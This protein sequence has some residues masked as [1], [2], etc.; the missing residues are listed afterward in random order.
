[1]ESNKQINLSAIRD[2]QWVYTKH[3]LD[4]LELTTLNLIKADMTVCD[5]GTGWGFPLMPLAI[6]YPKTHFIWLDSTAKKLKA[7]NHIT[8]T[9][10]I[11]NVKTIR[12]RAED[13]KQKY[14]IITARAVS[15]IDT[16][17]SWTSHL[18][19]PSGLLVLYK[20]KNADEYHD[21][22]S[23]IPDFWLE[24]IDQHEYTIS[25]DDIQ[26]ILYILKKK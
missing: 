4:S 1:M 7:I 21:L 17:L 12:S 8:N 24:L 11:S 16:F 20:Q 23:I 5:I 18:I 15:Y 22:V 26:R 14:D 6:R 2:E 25:S 10:D 9:M 13:H 3:I 19:K